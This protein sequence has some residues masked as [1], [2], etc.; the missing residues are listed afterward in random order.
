MRILGEMKALEKPHEELHH[1][2]KEII[3]AKEAGRSDEAQMLYQQIDPLSKKIIG[4]LDDV[5]AKVS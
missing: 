2:I 3:E 5:E 1:L 4:L